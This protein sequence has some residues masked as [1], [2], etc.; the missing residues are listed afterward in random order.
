MNPQLSQNF[1]LYWTC[2]EAVRT[3][4]KASFIPSQY[5]PFCLG[6]RSTVTEKDQDPGP[7]IRCQS[8]ANTERHGYPMK[9]PKEFF[10]PVLCVA[11]HCLSDGWQAP[12]SI[13]K[14]FQHQMVDAL[15]KVWVTITRI[16]MTNRTPSQLLSPT[17]CAVRQPQ[18]CKQSKARSRAKEPLHVFICSGVQERN[19]CA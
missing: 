9:T 3:V 2:C 16:A 5:R 13:W 6:C 17:N 19:L 11:L 1:G 15:P 12:Q 14:H 18:N 7:L 10:I 8:K 4:R